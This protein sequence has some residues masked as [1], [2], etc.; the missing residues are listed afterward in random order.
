VIIACW[1]ISVVILQLIAGVDT[2][3]AEKRKEQDE[4]LYMYCLHRTL[5][6]CTHC[7]IAFEVQDLTEQ[8]NIEWHCECCHNDF[9]EYATHSI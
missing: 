8:M 6:I 7:R 2:Y 3:M 9:T 5:V 1:T 4:A